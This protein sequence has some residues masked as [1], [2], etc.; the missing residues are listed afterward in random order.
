MTAGHGEEQRMLEAV[1]RHERSSAFAEAERVI[2]AVLSDPQVQ[3]ARARI[4]AAESG[5]GTELS[6]LLQLFQDHY[7]QAVRES[8]TAVLTGNCPGKHDRWGRICVLDNGHETA[9][10]EPHRGQQQR[11]PADRLSEQ[12][13]RRLVS[14]PR[15]ERNSDEH[16]YTAG[17]DPALSRDPVHR[18]ARYQTGGVNARLKVL[19]F[20]QAQGVPAVEADDLVA[21]LEAGAVAGAHSEVAE[22]DERAP[23][24]RGPEFVDGWDDGVTALC[25]GL[26]RIADRV[27]AHRGGR[28]ERAG[29]LAMHLVGLVSVRYGSVAGA[30]DGGR[31]L[32]GC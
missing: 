30:A 29:E 6:A 21:A 24:S 1:Q 5:L 10:K 22:L 12:R 14:A 18:V 20:L 28:S 26:V 25:E 16:H 17:P 13:T 4:E 9:M 15:C 19:A 2:S 32:K 8:D 3:Q 23:A 11:R 7:E 27:W 31:M